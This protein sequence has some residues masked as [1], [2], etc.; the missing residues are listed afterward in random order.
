[1]D[2]SSRPIQIFGTYG[3]KRST[4]RT[5]WSPAALFSNS[6][7]IVTPTLIWLYTLPMSPRLHS[8]DNNKLVSSMEAINHNLAWAFE[9]FQ[10]SPND[11]IATTC[12]NILNIAKCGPSNDPL[13]YYTDMNDCM[14]FMAS[15]P[16]GTLDK[17]RDNSVV[18]RQYHSTLAIARPNVHCSDSGKTRG[19]KC[20]VSNYADYYLS[21]Y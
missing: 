12:N 18:C 15:I 13:G 21:N 9:N 5:T 1:M 14:N 2:Q 3:S 10:L 8:F 16:L 11:L 6:T 19:G 17:A 4:F 20:I 7:T